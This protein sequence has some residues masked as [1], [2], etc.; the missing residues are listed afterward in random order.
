MGKSEI[1][2]DL[3]FCRKCWFKYDSTEHLIETLKSVKYLTCL[4]CGETRK[5]T[6]ESR[7]ALD[8]R[9]KKRREQRRI[10]SK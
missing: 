1:T 5:I 4:K 3:G 8:R 7:E 9:N 10:K 2:Y 6:F